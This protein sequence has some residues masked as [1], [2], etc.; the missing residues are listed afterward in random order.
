MALDSNAIDKLL[1]LLKARPVKTPAVKTVIPK[2]VNS[3]STGIYKIP[4]SEK[5]FS[6]Y[7]A[8]PISSKVVERLKPVTGKEYSYA[9][10]ALLSKNPTYKYVQSCKVGTNPTTYW[11]L[12]TSKV[13]IIRVKDFPDRSEISYSEGITLV[14]TEREVDKIIK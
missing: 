3:I 10:T 8:K 11:F 13:N 1:L 14:L 6:I 4:E 9:I 7:F 2:V 5:P 12:D